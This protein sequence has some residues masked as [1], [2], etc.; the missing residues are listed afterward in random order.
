M[1]IT[2]VT[3]L[4]T[5]HS[6]IITLTIFLLAVSFF[7]ITRHFCM[8]I[9]GLSFGLCLRLSFK[10]IIEVIAVIFASYTGALGRAQFSY[11]KAFAIHF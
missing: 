11:R 10:L 2:A 5:L 9:I 7:T 1:A 4:S 6:C 3:S 8:S